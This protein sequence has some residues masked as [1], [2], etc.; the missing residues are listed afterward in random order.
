[1]EM[2]GLRGPNLLAQTIFLSIIILEDT[3]VKFGLLN[4]TIFL[5]RWFDSAFQDI[6]NKL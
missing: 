5:K 3:L 6:F 2:H 1:M 4:G